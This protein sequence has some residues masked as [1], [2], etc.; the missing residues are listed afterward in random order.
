MRKWTKRLLIS[1]GILI[2]LLLAAIILVPILFKDKIEA[3]VKDEVNKN[4]NATVDWGEWDISLLRNFPNLTVD[5]ADVKVANLAPFEGVELANI[6]SLTAT[7]DIMSLFGDR[8]D[9]KRV[10]L[11]RPRI[12]VRVLEDGRAN[13]DIAKADTTAAEA[14]ADT[15]ASKF[16]VG[17]EEYW[18]EDGRVIYDDASLKYYM[19]LLGLDHK[20]SGDFTQDLFV[21]NTTTHADTVNV[22]FDG[23]KYLR[24]VKT[25]ITANLEMDMPNMK[26]TFKDNEASIN[27]LVLGFD[28]WL[29]MPGDDIDMDLTWNAKK[30]DFGTLLSLVPAEFATDLTGVQMSGKAA[31]NGSV[32]GKYNDTSM[33]GF[34]LVV[35]VD[36]GRF[37]YPDLPN[38]VEDIYVDLKINS[39]GG[40]DMD[41]MVI[42]LKRFG[43]TMAGNPVEARMHL[44]K[45]MSDP[46]VDAELKANLDLASVK[47]VV[48]MK[49]DELEGNFTAD[50]RMKGAMSDIE[51]QHYDKFTADGRMILLGMKYDADSMPSI[52][53][54]SLYFDFS[55]RYLALTSFDGS[56]GSSSVQAKGRL[57]NYLQWWLKDSTLVGSFDLAANKFDLN[58]LMGPSE[59]ASASTEAATADTAAMSVIEVPGNI[60]FRM[61]IGVKEVIYDQLHLTNVRGGMRVHDKRVDLNDVFFNLFGGSVTMSG[62]YE[63]MDPKAPRIDLTYDVRDL[64]IEQTV[65]YVDMVQK[66]APIAKTCKGSFSTTLSMEARLNERM[67]PDMNT[68][69]GD[70][71][72]VTRSVQVD[73]FEPLVKLA[74]ALKIKQLEN[75]RLQDVSFSYELRDGKMITKE[76]PVKIDRISARVGGSTAFADQ[77]IDYDLKAK[78][79]SDM[80]GAG[81]AQAVAGLLGQVNQAVGGNFEV[82]KEL[83]MTAKITGTID[84][85]IV[86][87]VFA[88]GTTNVKDVIVQEVKQELNEQIGKAREEAIARAKEERDRLVAEAQA[89]ADKLKADA[90]RE[91]ANVKAQAYKAADDALAQVKDPFGKMAAKVVADK[92]KKEADRKE[93]QAIAEADKRADSLLDAA[94]KKGDELVVKAEATDTTIK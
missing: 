28:G 68:L 43:M 66:M 56:V 64:D 84:K 20:G 55:P 31:F 76:F 70:G 83:D 16:N 80:F 33:P 34:D 94:R 72:L 45:P 1:S 63:A 7:I 77:A 24:N 22:V 69:T 26:F 93:Q 17:L 5:I 23:V 40:A 44:T 42:D 29:A 58:E 8:I 67:E 14:P 6:G 46:N 88:G 90:R 60:D 75:T 11:V 57:D 2:F 38:S 92:A 52:G 10:G 91:A 53:I 71:T 61:G 18:I 39:P 12:H 59:P 82:P 13:W 3:A 49:G 41:K 32:K 54:N 4:I 35:D 73:G 30:T 27:Q 36:K 50:V 21:L 15:A 48:P 51:A 25:D 89:Q 9:I 74:Q 47:T 87:P 85:P 81:A 37:K 86:K 78:I 79:P 19:D 62:G 65:T